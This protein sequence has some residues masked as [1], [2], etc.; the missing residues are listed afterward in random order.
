MAKNDLFGLERES[1]IEK[2][3]IRKIF[4]PHKPVESSDFFFGRQKEV[5]KLIEQL[6]TPGQHSLL[7][8]DRGVGKSSLANVVTV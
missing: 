1:K 5:Q 6:N 2:S 4:T 3:G 7:Y 8:G